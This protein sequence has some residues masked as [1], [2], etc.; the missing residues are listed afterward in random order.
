MKLT[1]EDARKIQ[2]FLENNYV[3]GWTGNVDNII[4]DLTEIELVGQIEPQVSLGDSQPVQ[5]AE[6]LDFGDYCLI[7][8]KRYGIDNE[9]YLHKVIK[10]LES[11]TYVDVPVQ[12]PAKEKVHNKMEKVIACICCG[13]SETEVRKYRLKDIKL[14]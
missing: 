3:F 2:D 4:K 6:S 11:N 5:T 9:L 14:R 7:E 13:V 1:L 8:Q 12:T 10:Q